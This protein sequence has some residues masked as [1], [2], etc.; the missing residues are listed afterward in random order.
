[1][2]ARGSV[3][4]SQAI[5]GPPTPFIAAGLAYRYREDADGNPRIEI[6]SMHLTRRR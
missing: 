3:I 1:L 6:V 2:T 5:D 4:Y